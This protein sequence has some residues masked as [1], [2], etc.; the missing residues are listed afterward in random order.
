MPLHIY[1]EHLI[2]IRTLTIQ[3]TLPS[4]SN[5]ETSCTLSTDGSVLTL[6]HQ[7]ET[8]SIRL[9]VPIPADARASVNIPVVPTKELSFRVRLG[10][11]DSLQDRQSSETII[12]WAAASLFH[13]AELRCKDCRTVIL[14]QGRI[15]TWKN[16]PS[17]GWAEMMEFWHC[18]KPN[19][20][21]NHEQ[22]TDKKGY[23]ADSKLAITPS[24]GLV[25]ATSF[26]LAAVDCDNIKV[27]GSL[28]FYCGQL[29]VTRALK[30]TG[31][32]RPQ[33]YFIWKIRDIAAQ[34]QSFPRRGTC[35]NPCASY[36][37]SGEAM[38][39]TSCDLIVPSSSSSA[40]RISAHRYILKYSTKYT[41]MPL[42]SASVKSMLINFL[43]RRLTVLR[44]RTRIPTWNVPRAT[45]LLASWI[46]RLGATRW[47]SWHLLSP[48][49][50]AI[51]RAST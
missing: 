18:H 25:N 45:P 19:E 20:P 49:A 51:N 40:W 29:G 33:G 47:L 3:S 38:L 8:A 42:H 48:R 12:P 32:S 43:L 15:Q 36:G 41:I 13:H 31:A 11:T 7:G 1:A 24:V 5:E 35:C 37:F 17:E 26:I 30:R 23:S 10:Y 46:S 6:V 9:P 50:Q 21:H 27:G 28:S 39:L 44:A 2:N 4:H 34:E 14:P 16:L 22:Q